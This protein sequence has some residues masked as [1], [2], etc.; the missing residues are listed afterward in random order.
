MKFSIIKHLLYILIALIVLVSCKG[1]DEVTIFFQPYENFSKSEINHIQADLEKHFAPLVPTKLSFKV[2]DKT[3]LPNDCLNKSKTRYRARKLLDNLSKIDIPRRS[4]II[5]L[6]HKDI[7]TT[8][9][10]V[11]DYGIL[12]QSLVGGIV[13]IVSDHR[14][15]NKRDTWKVVSHEFIHAYYNYGH[16]PNDDVTCII[17]DAKGKENL[18]LKYHL[19]ETC[20]KKIK[21]KCLFKCVVGLSF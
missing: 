3:S 16:C 8:V 7:S 13:C 5:G 6:T 11:D 20:T 2:L 17:K 15:R 9:H 19:C 14:I 10:G 4:V 18:K 12:G 1:E 21:M